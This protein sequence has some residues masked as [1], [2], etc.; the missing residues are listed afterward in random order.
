MMALDKLALIIIF[1]IILIIGA[2]LI[3]QNVLPA[4]ENINLETELTN[5][6]SK[7][8]AYGCPDNPTLIPDIQC[9]EHDLYTLAFDFLDFQ[10]VEDLQTFCS[11]PP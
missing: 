8:R 9:N 7:Y 2:I 5:C 11:C 4:G 10:S 1:L 6:C 3:S